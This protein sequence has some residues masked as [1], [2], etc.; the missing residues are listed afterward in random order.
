MTCEDFGSQCSDSVTNG[1]LNFRVNGWSSL[2]TIYL[3]TLA[4]VRQQAVDM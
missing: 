1:G 3:H 4:V 2:S